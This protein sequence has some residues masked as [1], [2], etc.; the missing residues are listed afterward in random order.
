MGEIVGEF[1][2]EIVGI[3]VVGGSKYSISMLTVGSA[4]I[5]CDVVA[6]D[7]ESEFDGDNI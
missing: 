3:D 7:A 1:V 5:I 2:G 4:V 6:D